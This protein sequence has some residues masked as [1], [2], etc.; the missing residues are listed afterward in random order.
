MVC[1]S[2]WQSLREAYALS[3]GRR[4]EP[5]RMIPRPLQRG[6]VMVPRPMQLA[7]V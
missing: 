5:W 6:Q 4:S 7:H 1:R 3:L 2:L